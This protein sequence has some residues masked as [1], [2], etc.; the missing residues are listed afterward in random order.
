MILDDCRNAVNE[1]LQ[2]EGGVLFQRKATKNWEQMATLVRN[3]WNAYKDWERDIDTFNDAVSHDRM[4][5]R[6]FGAKFT[7][8]VDKTFEKG[9]LGLSAERFF[10]DS[11]YSPVDDQGGTRK[12]AFDNPE[13]KKHYGANRGIRG[14]AF[15]VPENFASREAKYKAGTHDLSASL[16]DHKYDMFDRVG[17]GRKQNHHTEDGAHFV[18]LPLSKEDD[19]EVIFNLVRAAKAMR[20]TVPDLYALVRDY[21][22]KMTRVKLAADFDMGVG[23]TAV[24]SASTANEGPHFKLRYGLL[25][26][27]TQRGVGGDGQETVSVTTETYQARQQAGIR[28]KSVLAAARGRKNEIVVAVRQHA[29]A[30]PVYAERN[31]MELRCF[32]LEG[33]TKVFTGGTVSVKGVLTGA[34]T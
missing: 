17:G 33:N 19:Q 10:Q 26:A 6:T 29:G 31:G 22:S 7:K 1:H 25:A 5:L 34:G 16:F 9:S 28:F 2:P 23:Y 8:E 4:T 20:G 14:S 21:R 3:W 32:R 12:L 18:F 27:M 30:F 15:A 11:R 24:P 13:E